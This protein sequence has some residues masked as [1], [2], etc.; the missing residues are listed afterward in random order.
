M[1]NSHTLISIFGSFCNP[2]EFLIN[3]WIF[4]WI[5]LDFLALK[6][7]IL[8]KPITQIWIVELP[9]WEFKEGD[10]GKSF[11]T[12]VAPVGAQRTE[13]LPSI[14]HFFWVQNNGLLPS[15]MDGT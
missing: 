2:W 4:F 3:F 11:P 14:H 7:I 1:E 12:V 6:H 9:K 10:C 5:F 15:T 13:S 8:H